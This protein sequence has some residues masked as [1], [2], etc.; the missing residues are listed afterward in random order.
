[1]NFLGNYKDWIKPEL[2]EYLLSN[3]GVRRPDA[4]ENPDCEEFKLAPSVGYDLSKT[5]WHFY[6]EKSFPFEIQL[7]F[8]T[9]QKFTWWFIKMMP[10]HYMPMH[11]DPHVTK[12]SD[13]SNCSRYWMPL[14]DYS[15]GHVF[16][17][18]DEMIT[19]YTAGDL[20][21]YTDA[22]A[23]HGACNIGYLPRLTFLFTTY[24]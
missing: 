11:R 10:G 22:N 13:K 6:N 20:W 15:P 2:I 16:I 4:G 12:D 14:Q 9:D 1:M 3:D 7:P 18:D 21:K 17:Y 19:R 24:D 8:E 23:I 5:W